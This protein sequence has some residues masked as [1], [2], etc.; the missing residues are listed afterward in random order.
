MRIRFKRLNRNT[1]QT[2]IRT[3]VLAYLLLHSNNNKVQIRRF[4]IVIINANSGK[5]ISLVSWGFASWVP[6]LGQILESPVLTLSTLPIS[7]EKFA[8]TAIFITVW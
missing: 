1:R 4:S 8:A 3:K 2:V 7:R 6:H 5:V